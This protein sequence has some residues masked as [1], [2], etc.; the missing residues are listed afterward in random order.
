VLLNV[1]E[2]IYGMNG[3]SDDDDYDDGTREI[4]KNLRNTL[5]QAEK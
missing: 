1:N 2:S 4:D 5:S 3:H